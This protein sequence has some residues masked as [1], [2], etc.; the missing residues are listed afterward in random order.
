MNCR[1][2]GYVYIAFDLRCINLVDSHSTVP[3]LSEYLVSILLCK[4]NFKYTQIL[5]VYSTVFY[6]SFIRGVQTF[7]MFFFAF[8]NH[9]FNV[10][11]RNS[12]RAYSF[13]S[14]CIYIFHL[15]FIFT[16]ARSFRL[17]LWNA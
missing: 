15:F 11:I 13:N 14:A 4:Q 3:Y 8:L 12:T 7:Y 17:D 16:G 1:K 10:A 6:H 5:I 2:H 9:S